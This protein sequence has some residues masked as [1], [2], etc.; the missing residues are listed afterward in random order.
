MAFGAFFDLMLSFVNGTVTEAMLQKLEQTRV[1]G[2]TLSVAYDF[3]L[4]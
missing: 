4:A 2:R 3:S 1:M